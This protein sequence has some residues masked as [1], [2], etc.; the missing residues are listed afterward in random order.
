MK[1]V[2][3]VFLVLIL[4]MFQFVPFIPVMA[5]ELDE[6]SKYLVAYSYYATDV[7]V[8]CHDTYDEAVEKMN[9]L[10]SDQ[11]KVAVVKYNN[12]II[13]AKYALVRMN[14][15]QYK[16]DGTYNT[17]K[18]ESLIYL[19]GG[20]NSTIN[21]SYIN[22]RWSID[23]AFLGYDNASKKVNFMLSGYSGWTSI[24]NVGIVPISKFFKPTARVT[25]TAGLN[26]RANPNGNVLATVLYNTVCT[27]DA[28]KTEV[29]ENNV[30]WMYA[31]CSVN[32]NS[33]TGYMSK[34][35]LKLGY[36]NN[37]FTM[38]VHEQN[39]TSAEIRHYYRYQSS[40]GVISKQNVLLGLAPAEFKPDVRY[41]SFDSNY[42]YDDVF[43]MLDDYKNKTYE[44]S[45]NPNTPYYAYF[46]YLPGHSETGYTAETFDAILENKYG[47]TEGPK[48]DVTYV[49]SSCS[50]VNKPA[51]N[52]S[53]M[54]N[55]GQYFIEA[56]STYGNNALLA[57]SKAISESA[58]GKSTIAFYKN[59]LFGMGA[60]D[61]APCLNARNYETARE[62]ILDYAR[63]TSAGSSYSNPKDYRYAGGHYGNKVA[64]MNVMYASDAY[65]GEKAAQE[66]YLNDKSYGKL[67]YNSNTL[68]I[69]DSSSIVNVYKSPS[70]TSSVIYSTTRTYN[71]AL[72]IVKQTSFIVTEK[73]VGTD[74]L[75]YYR[76][77]TDPALDANQNIT[78]SY[79]TFENS[80][81]YVLAS[82]LYV[83]NKEP[84]ITVSDLETKQGTKI[85]LLQ[86]VKATDPE[87][88]ELTEIIVDDS[89]VDYY[90]PNTYKVYYKVT[91]SNHF[92]K[93]ATANL[94]VT[95]AG[96]PIIRGT[97]VTITALK[98]FDPKSGIEIISDEELMDKLKYTIKKGEEIVTL[99]EMLANVGDYKIHY[100]VKNSF[101]KEALTYIR[102]VKVVVNNYPVINAS[103]ITIKQNSVPNYY[104]NVT[105]TDIEDGNL[106]NSLV[107]DSSGVDLRNPGQY[108]L[109]YSV[110]DL[111]NQKT[112]LTVSVVVEEIDYVSKDG[113][114]HLEKLEFNKETN[115][116][117][118]L[119]FLNMNGI[120]ITDS[121]NI[122][123]DLVLENQYSSKTVIY[124]LNRLLVDV[125]FNA[126]DS[127]K[128]WFVGYIGLDYIEDG[129]YTIYLRCRY[130]NYE[131]KIKA[132]NP[133]FN[134]N[135]IGKFEYNNK[136]YFL[137]NNYSSRTLQI[138]L[139]VRSDGLFTYDDNNKLYN[140]Y[141]Q[142]YSIGLQDNYLSIKGTSH[143]YGKDYGSSVNVTRNMIFENIKTFSRTSFN[144]GSIT[145]GPYKVSF[146]VPDNKDKT[147][148]WYDSKI[149]ISTLPV[150]TY[151][152]YINTKTNDVNDFGEIYDY[153]WQ[154]I[155]FSS[156]YT[157]NGVEYKARVVRNNNIRFRIELIIEEK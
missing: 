7:P 31:T 156:T 78:N 90:V 47:I 157:K 137:R 45:I 106:I 95:E 153:L 23:A 110:T 22:G 36:E 84:S 71:G 152:I 16:S 8:S 96:Y 147:R 127:N 72:F 29:D 52:V 133:F 35:F 33:Y 41:Y 132:T 2:F 21:Y 46:M 70:K 65:W 107:V 39:G 44:N 14:M 109:I 149:D 10:E 9:S 6:C 125:P 85:D 81:G 25:A 58:A 69:K 142:V 88:G 108:D 139:F 100:D 99:E 18:S 97:D 51:N 128:S 50:W 123:Y 76:V 131:T 112:T 135:L 83:V 77:Y 136:G 102:N 61:N 126:L 5:T 27:Y 26:L 63:E 15:Y 141:N 89:E 59:N 119:G 34:E 28:T 138:E 155:E 117:E 129:D 73:V 37:I 13:N 57:F 1:K 143:T 53:V 87:D 48:E 3:K 79:Y 114:L 154:D 113:Y 62:S 38:Y 56:Q 12:K 92:S 66:A 111:D 11:S 121:T 86:N 20:I 54:Y 98:S 74:G 49:N 4:V 55:T 68:G 40:Y 145:N 24:D 82:D 134:Q 148:T 104:N 42:F 116:L 146:A 64:G 118:V 120:K 32:G 101:D 144:I 94:T 30:T 122:V 67:D 130:S 43:K 103:N 75:E 80:Y 140:M 105:A 93:R 151:S 60:S 19:Y 124:S 17:S 150:G 115:R 91:D